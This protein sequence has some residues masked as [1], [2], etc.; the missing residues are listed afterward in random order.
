MIAGFSISTLI[1]IAVAVLI[2]LAVD[3]IAF[4]RH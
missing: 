2:V 4:N 3:Y 1:V